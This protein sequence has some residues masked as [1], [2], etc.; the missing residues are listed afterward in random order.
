M[1]QYCEENGSIKNAQAL[2]LV[3]AQFCFVGNFQLKH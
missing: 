2:C 1:D 3:Y